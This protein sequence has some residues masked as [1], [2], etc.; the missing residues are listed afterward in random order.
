MPESTTREHAAQSP[1][2]V[3]GVGGSGTRVVAE[4]LQRLGYF[5]GADLNESLDNLWFSMLFKRNQWFVAERSAADPELLASWELFDKAMGN[6]PKLTRDERKLVAVAQAEMRENL[7]QR[8]GEDHEEWCSQRAKSLLRAAR[9]PAP[10][11]KWG[12]KE[13]NSHA[14]LAELNQRYS[15]LRYVHV[16]RSGLDMAF[17]RNQTQLDNW[18]AAFG[19]APPQSDAEVPAASLEFWCIA[20]QRAIDRGRQ[21]LGDRFLLLRFEDL[22]ATPTECILELATFL[23]DEIKPE[24]LEELSEIPREPASVGRFRSQDLSSFRKEH[25]RIVSELGFATE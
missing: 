10:Q 9:K 18:G 11:F 21:V 19:V 23:G 13:P 4:I 25:L 14:Y 12:W 17:S 6:G 20:N 22:C 24:V 1:V 7:L 8:W 3:G 16:I 5:I 2:V 15:G